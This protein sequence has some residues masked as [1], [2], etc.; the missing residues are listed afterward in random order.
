MGTIILFVIFIKKNIKIVLLTTVVE[1][2]IDF[3]RVNERVDRKVCRDKKIIAVAR[4]TETG[5]L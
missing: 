3:I 2:K 5:T 1:V 4:T